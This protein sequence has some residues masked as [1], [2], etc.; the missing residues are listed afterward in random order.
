MLRRMFGGNA[1]SGISFHRRSDLGW[2]AG[3]GE[4]I[5]C[6]RSVRKSPS[7]LPVLQG[8]ERN[9]VDRREGALGQFQTATKLADIRNI[10]AAH[11]VGF[12]ARGRR[13]LAEIVSATVASCSHRVKASPGV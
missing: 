4:Q 11:P 10:Q 12:A 3:D 6:R 7:L 13:C 5:R 8:W 2:K 1:R 9:P